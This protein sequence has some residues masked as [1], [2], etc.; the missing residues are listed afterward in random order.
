MKLSA[1]LELVWQLAAREAMAGEFKEIEP[2]HVFVAVLK[3]AEM[4]LP[5]LVN[6]GAGA[7]VAT[8]LAGDVKAVQEELRTW[9]VDGIRT[10]RE[11]RAL[12]DKGGNP[13]LG[14]IIHRSPQ[15]REYFEAAAKVAAESQSDT[16]TVRHL[17][18]ALMTSPT[19]KMAQVVGGDVALKMPHLRKTP[20]LDA[21]GKD[22][23]KVDAQDACPAGGNRS[24]ECK[25]LLQALAREGRRSVLLVADSDE[26]VKSVVAEVAR[27]ITDKNAPDGLCGR[28]IVDITSMTGIM[29]G[30]DEARRRGVHLLSEAASTREVILHL[31]AIDFAGD[32]KGLEA[33]GVF[34]KAQL[35]GGRVQCIC[36]V[37]PSSYAFL[38]K[39]DRAWKQIAEIVY[40]QDKRAA[41]LPQEL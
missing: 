7:D 12:L 41:R 25:A 26:I 11:L 1:S 24:A 15:S 8:T 28:R 14:G 13:F 3:F 37:A 32:V 30:D 29:S 31:P 34:I 4:P 40:L 2:E 22:L 20:C 33:C 35:K 17:L 19:P 21:M 23:F 27:A 9:G 5:G 16:L 18:K 39:S 36:R 10:R 38:A 6:L